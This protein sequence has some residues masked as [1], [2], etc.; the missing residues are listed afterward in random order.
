MT[1][2][3][4][5]QDLAIPPV[6]KLKQA[7]RSVSFLTD[8]DAHTL[9]NDAYGMLV[10]G[11]SGDDAQALHGALAREGVATEVVEDRQL[12]P[13]P[14][15]KFV[16]RLDCQPEGLMVYDPLGRNFRLEWGHIMLIAAGNVRVVDFKQVQKRREIV[17]YDGR[18]YPH[19]ETVVETGSKEER[20]YHLLL[21]L[22]LSRAV[23][24]FSVAVDRFNF[25]YLG[26]RLTND[27]TYNF[28]LLVQDLTKYAPAAA[29]NRGAYYLR[30]NASEIVS[31]PSKNAFVEEITWLLWRSNQA[32]SAD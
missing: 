11:L 21:E 16:H 22:V 23:Q 20:N 13:L 27:A 2:A 24:R 8:L 12:P 4:V 6:D 25:S 26:D 29:I 5:Q 30:E 17:N 9:A 15:T 1:F 32:R 10:R 7:F 3:I 14:P 18:G 28:T 31:Y 19:S